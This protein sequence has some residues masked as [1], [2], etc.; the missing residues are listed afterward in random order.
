MSAGTTAW[1]ACNYLGDPSAPIGDPARRL[2]TD[3]IDEGRTVAEART[4][5]RSR[6][7]LT[8]VTHTGRRAYPGGIRGSFD[9]CSQHKDQVQD[10]SD[11]VSSQ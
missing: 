11:Q 7:W 9:F 3:R 2:C 5:A 10:S 6:G 8:A 4:I 1:V